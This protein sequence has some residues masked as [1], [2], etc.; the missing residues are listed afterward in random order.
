MNG[1]Y[2]LNDDDRN[3]LFHT[4]RRLFHQKRRKQTV[5]TDTM[6]GLITT[7][8][9]YSALGG[10]LGLKFYATLSTELGE[11]KME[12]LVRTSNLEPKEIDRAVWGCISPEIFR[13]L[14]VV[15]Q[16]N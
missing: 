13:K 8:G 6:E 4:A 12:Y 11:K 1:G 7:R 3:L 5:K 15:G 14:S 9:E 10:T 16:N 2:S